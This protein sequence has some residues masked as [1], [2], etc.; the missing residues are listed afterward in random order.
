[1]MN[2]ELNSI[3]GQ[4]KAE[5]ETLIIAV[6]SNSNGTLDLSGIFGKEQS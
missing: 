6:R 3:S 2:V 5:N 4:Y 1:M